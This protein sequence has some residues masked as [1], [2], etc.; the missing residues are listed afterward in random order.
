MDHQGRKELESVNEDKGR[1]QKLGE[2]QVRC[3]VP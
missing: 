1:E 2:V 3:C